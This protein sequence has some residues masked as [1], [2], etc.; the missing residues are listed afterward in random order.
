MGLNG[1]AYGLVANSGYSQISHF[2]DAM[3]AA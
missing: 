1:L 3:F 2:S